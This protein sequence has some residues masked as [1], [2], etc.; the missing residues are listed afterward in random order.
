MCAAR[1]G[2]RAAGA[3]YA[4]SVL[5]PPGKAL[6]GRAE[7]ARARLAVLQNLARRLS[8]AS[9]AQDAFFGF[10]GRLWQVYPIDLMLGVHVEGL[11]PGYA[12][13]TVMTG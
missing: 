9:S 11:A 1:G 7:G 3:G 4:R 2:H 13:L 8:R 10:V 6:E 5:E 12:T